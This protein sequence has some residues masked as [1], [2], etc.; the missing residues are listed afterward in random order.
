M[1]FSFPL[2]SNSGLVDHQHHEFRNLTNLGPRV[3]V[4]KPSHR[5][6]LI[7]FTRKEYTYWGVQ[8]N[9]NLIGYPIAIDTAQPPAMFIPRIVPVNFKP[10]LV[11]QWITYCDQHH[12]SLCARVNQPLQGLLLVDCHGENRHH[13]IEAPF[14]TP[15]V[16]L[17]YVWSSS[18]S[19]LAYDLDLSGDGKPKLPPALPLVIEDAIK[20]VKAL[21]FCYLWIDKFCI[22]QRNNRKKDMQ[23]RHMD[24]IYETADLTIIAAAG[25]D[26]DFGLAGVSKPSR[27]TQ[28]VAIVND[29]LSVISSLRDP[30]DSIRRSKWSTRGWTFQEGVLSRR[31]L[32]FTKEQV[33]FECNAMN[34]YESLQSP[35]DKLHIRGRTKM[36]DAFR[37]GLFRGS[38]KHTQFGH[39]D[40]SMLQ[41]HHSFIQYLEAVEQYSSRTIRYENDSLNAFRG[42]MRSFAMRKHSVRQLWGLP[43]PVMD[44]FTEACRYFADSLTWY[45]R[46]DRFSL[47]S[48]A[49]ANQP[50]RPQFPSW[51]WAGWEGEIVYP[52]RDLRYYDSGSAFRSLVQV[53]D[54]SQELFTRFLEESSTPDLEVESTKELVLRAEE[55]PADRI[56][57]RGGTTGWHVNIRGKHGAATLFP[58]TRG[59]GDF[60][61]LLTQETIR[62]I[63]IGGVLEGHRYAVQI[64]VLEKKDLGDSRNVYSRIGMLVA[65]FHKSLHDVSVWDSRA[66]EQPTQSVFSII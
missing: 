37:A 43:M 48:H 61:N 13:L 60:S 49:P 42:V 25:E 53:I 27:T 23:I 7:I 50:R 45:H 62:F 30:H 15:F 52:C 40:P 59:P 10:D 21:G 55:I 63:V 58:S 38:Q 17:S 39:L 35:L 54:P 41:L 3:L 47:S 6:A 22:D 9:A 51:S 33:Y 56:S 2:L 64:M 46:R 24:V 1:L 31:R 20:V 65:Y 14:N 11:T 19:T 44:D 28:P 26:E 29:N 5:S 36:S 16:A 66:E 34:C 8:K 12:N 32:V 18:K 4:V 57:C